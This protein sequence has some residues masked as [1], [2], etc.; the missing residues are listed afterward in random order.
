MAP[1]FDT[2]NSL[3]YNQDFIPHG[4]A[5]LDIP[6]AS[7]CK[8]E[9]ELLRYVT[10]YGLVDLGRL[11]GFPGIV[12]QQLSDHTDMPTQRMENIAGTVEE[13][14]RRMPWTIM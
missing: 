7:F 8:R 13:K 5:L 11:K 10:D 14:L 3:F 1:I 12:Y 2:G 6:V 4:E 9:A